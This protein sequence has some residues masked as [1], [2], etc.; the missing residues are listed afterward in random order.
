MGWLVVCEAFASFQIGTGE[1]AEHKRND[2][3]SEPLHWPLVTTVW[4]TKEETP[5]ILH[6]VQGL[7][8]LAEK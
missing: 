2:L 5:R 4:G 8:S 7:C 6:F 3:P 1:A